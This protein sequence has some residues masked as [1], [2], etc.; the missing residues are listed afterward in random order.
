MLIGSCLAVIVLLQAGTLIAAADFEDDPLVFDDFPL[1]DPLKYPPWF[2]QSFL[3]FPEDLEE[4]LQKKKQ[5]IIVYFGQKRCAYCRMLIETN[6]AHPDIVNYTRKH[7]DL[8]PIDIRGIDDVTDFQG[9]ELSVRDYVSREKADLTPSLIFY[10]KEGKKVFMLRGY[11]PPYKFRAALEYV[12]D[13]HYKKE[14]FA[15]YLER[16]DTIM[17]FE[18]GELNDE[19]FFVPPPHN[20]DRSRFRGERPLV[21]F[22]E[23]TNCHACDVLH[24]QPLREPAINKQFQSFD[25]VQIDIWSDA[26]V[27]TPDGR[28][29]TAKEWA[30]S[31]GLFYAPSMVFFDEGGKEIIRLDSVVHFFRLRNVLNYVTSKGYL[32]EPNFMRWRMSSGFRL[33]N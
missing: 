22:F 32:A 13:G 5:G 12:A 27:V 2:K 17:R 25:N 14:T 6:F 1:E 23:Q 16:G 3:D 29:M 9:N 20:L 8:I 10:D 11:Y 15:A 24:A 7:F 4:A 19:E 31:L 28:R 33:G 18:T 26:P 30:R 21:V